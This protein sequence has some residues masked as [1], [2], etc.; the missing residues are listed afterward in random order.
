MSGADVCADKLRPLI[1]TTGAA[2]QW[3]PADA[4]GEEL[5]G[6]VR[7]GLAFRSQHRGRRPGFAAQLVC[8]AAARIP[9]PPTFAALL[10]ELESMAVRR[11]MY[12]AYADNPVEKVDRIWGLVTIHDPKQGRVQVAFKT[13]QNH[14]TNCRKPSPGA[15]SRD[16]LSGESSPVESTGLQ[17]ESHDE[18]H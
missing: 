9:Q 12:R 17:Q 18:Q 16:P 8:A 14:L 5:L 6:L 15:A 3:L 2:A 7:I 4:I 1:T 13:L 10:E 11:A